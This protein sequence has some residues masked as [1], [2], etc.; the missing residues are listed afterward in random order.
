MSMSFS[1]FSV[2]LF[3]F[4]SVWL[5]L[6]YLFSFAVWLMFDVFCLRSFG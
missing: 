1:L 5:G 2:V 6:V 4:V 3:W